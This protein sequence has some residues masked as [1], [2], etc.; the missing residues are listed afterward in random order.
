MSLS[1]LNGC[2]TSGVLTAMSLSASS[3]SLVANSPSGVPDNLPL[4]FTVVGSF[5]E[6]SNAQKVARSINGYDV[7]VV[8]ANTRDGLR[9][10]VLVSNGDSHPTSPGALVAEGFTGAWS[11]TLCGASRNPPPC[12]Q[13]ELVAPEL[14]A[15]AGN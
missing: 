6:W 2:A 3:V 9:F 4:S 8:R 15:V 11:V 12:E 7:Q 14:V 10:P 13:P 1:V 5:A